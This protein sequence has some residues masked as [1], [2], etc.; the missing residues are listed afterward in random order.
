MCIVGGNTYLED[1]SYYCIVS[2]TNS[3]V[4]FDHQNDG[5]FYIESF[6]ESDNSNTHLMFKLN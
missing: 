3:N 4:Q 1:A 2:R 5:P 6:I